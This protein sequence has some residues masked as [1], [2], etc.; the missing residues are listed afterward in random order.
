MVSSMGVCGRRTSQYPGGILWSKFYIDAE[1]MFA[2][3]SWLN[4]IR[5]YTVIAVTNI[6]DIYWFGNNI[7]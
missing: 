4:D 6:D 1:D 2:L 7:Y 5:E 3:C